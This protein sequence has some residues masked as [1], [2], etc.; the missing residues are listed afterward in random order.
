MAFGY[1]KSSCG[2]CDKCLG[3]LETFC[4]R[5]GFYGVDDLDV[6]SMASHAV[7]RESF[8]YKVPTGMSNETASALMCGGATVFNV[9]DMYN[10]K[11]TERVG[12]VGIGG[13]GHLAIQF[14]AKWGCE[15]IVFSRTE[16]KRKEAMELGAHEF[17]PTKGIDK[18]TDIA[19]I[20]HLMVLT[21]EQVPWQLYLSIMAQP[22]T[23]YPLTVVHPH[24][25]LQI[26][27]MAFLMSGLRIQASIIAPRS[28]QR[29]MLDFAA[30]HKIQPIGQH[31]K[32]D[33]AGIEQAMGDLRVGKMRYKAILS[34]A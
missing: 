2:T 9:L 4:P 18:F 23:I 22:G 7:F 13:L 26:P 30:R 10:V 31:Y 3:S 32:L 29:R 20:D 16:D 27:Y 33:L 12:V 14:A 8:L 1:Q 24:D 15:V 34:A 21:S 19:P 6:G 25:L 28:I 17:Y 5:R 11:P